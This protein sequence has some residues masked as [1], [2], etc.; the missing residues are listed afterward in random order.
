MKSLIKSPPC[1][2][3]VASVM[4]MVYVIR[5]VDQNSDHS[6]NDFWM[7]LWVLVEVSIGVSIL[8][9]FSLP[10]FIEAKGPKLRGFFLHLTRPLTFGRRSAAP[11]QRME[12]A[13]VTPEER[14]SSDT[15][16]TYEHSSE[17]KL[18]AF[19]NHDRDV[20]R[21]ASDEDVHDY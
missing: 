19:M 14:K 21:C 2:A 3:C 6:Y 1:R 9:T 18:V 12:D 10:K 13:R 5:G 16:A 4:M 17:S 8:G 7:I 15:F 11:V 20:E